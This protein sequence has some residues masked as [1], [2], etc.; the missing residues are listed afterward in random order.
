MPRAAAA[1]S[2]RCSP[3]AITS[4]PRSSPGSAAPGWAANR[5]SGPPPTVITRPC[6]SAC[7]PCSGTSA[8]RRSQQSHRQHFVDQRMQAASSKPAL[9][10]LP[11][12]AGRTPGRLA[13]TGGTRPTL[14][15]RTPGNLGVPQPGR[16]L[17]GGPGLHRGQAAALELAEQG[18]RIADAAR[19]VSD[20][21]WANVV[22][23]YDEDQAGQ[24]G[25]ASPAH[26]LRVLTSCGD[27][28]KNS[29]G[30]SVHGRS[31]LSPV[32]S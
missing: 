13:A 19:G 28:A 6:A 1:P 14:T 31:R 10:G 20:E 24:P 21:A 11:A 8:S 30:S 7:R 26:R 23:H 2:P 12:A 18:T 25:L 3:C 29:S 5:K 32:V 4:S 17:A 15:P 16:D 27:S 9:S 22:K